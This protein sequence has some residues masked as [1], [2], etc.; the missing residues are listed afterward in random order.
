SRPPTRPP[1]VSHA[2]RAPRP[3]P[4]KLASARKESDRPWTQVVAGSKRKTTADREEAIIALA[5]TFPSTTTIALQDAASAVAGQ[6]S[7]SPSQLCR[8]NIR[9]HTTYGGSRKQIHIFTMPPFTWNVAHFINQAN[10]RL[11]NDKST[12]RVTSVSSSRGDLSL[13]TTDV[14]SATDLESIEDLCK[15]A[16]AESSTDTEIRVEIPS[17]KSCL[18]ICNFPYFGLKVNK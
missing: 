10:S 12:L 16:L 4:S 5:K 18:K 15:K 1:P 7:F 2:M 17:S 3:I 14:P 9:K 6:T 11:G 8:K 13:E